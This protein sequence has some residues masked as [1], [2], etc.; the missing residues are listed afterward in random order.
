MRDVTGP[1]PVPGRRRLTFQARTGAD[2]IDQQIVVPAGGGPGD[3]RS[4]GGV[5]RVYNAAGTGEGVSVPLA[6]SG[7]VPY[8]DP[9]RPTG[10]RWSASSRTSAVTRVVVRPNRIR[11]RAGGALFGYSLDEAA[12]GAV[13][14]VLRLGTAPAWCASAPAKAAGTP[15]STEAY[16]R[17]D[18][19]I[20]ERNAPAPGTCPP[21]P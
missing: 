11:V 21:A 20:A 2:P 4:G 15:P 12:Q 6:A 9:A 16:D 19:F 3:P 18:R 5:L 13:A 8:G 10:Y 1:P 14:I 17:P 7:W